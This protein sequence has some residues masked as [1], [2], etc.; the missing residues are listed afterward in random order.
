MGWLSAA[1]MFL[2]IKGIGTSV[3][4]G[5]VSGAEKSAI[6][7]LQGT[8]DSLFIRE[9]IDHAGHR[10][11][12]YSIGES[13]E[14]IAFQGHKEDLSALIP[15]G[16]NIVPTTPE[17]ILTQALKINP[18]DKNLRSMLNNIK[19]KKYGAEEYD[20]LDSMAASYH[21][22]PKGEY[23]FRSPDNTS[24]FATLLSSLA[25]NKDAKNI[26]DNNKI[27]L[28]K[29]IEDSN[30]ASKS[31]SRGYYNESD[32][33]YT[34]ADP[35]TVPVIRS[36]SY[37]VTRNKDGSVDFQSAG[38]HR[39]G[40]ED[41]VPRA[42]IHTTLEAI[43]RSVFGGT[44]SPSETKV[45]SRLSDMLKA[46]GN[47]YNLGP[48]DTWWMKNIGDPLKFPD[49]SIIRPFTD[50]LKYSEELLKRG[51]IKPGEE[52]P[53]MFNDLSS[54]EIL[55]LSKPSY[56][57]ADRLSLL[58]IAPDYVDAS[59]RAEMQLG[60]AGKENAFLDEFALQAAKKQLGIKTDYR[61]IDGNAINSQERMNE[62]QSLGL[63]LGLTKGNTLHKGTPPKQLEERFGD[64]TLHGIGHGYYSS[65]RLHETDTIE[66][67]RMA[68]ANG[69]FKTDIVD[70]KRSMGD[71]DA[72]GGYI[73]FD[74]INKI[75]AATGGLIKN[76]TSLAKYKLPSYEVGSPY[77]PEDQIAQLHKGE[78]VLTAQENKNFSSSGPV[79]NNI[80][81]NGA[82]KDP[83]QIAQEVM[84]QLERMQ[85]KNNKTNLVGR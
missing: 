16:V 4:K 65:Y 27:S 32:Y 33:L 12:T 69:A 48:T 62:I 59:R 83:K 25:G 2:P 30:N 55:H 72:A 1:S 76:K 42:S 15:L 54:K 73:D 3:T 21:F 60:L 13:K 44:W 19:N 38:T 82:D 14:K 84:L 40:Q 34:Q 37:P 85:S 36:V 10:F 53:I 77:I 9:D 74:Y 68:V 8:A 70:I 80:T 5:A 41:E 71:G 46:N 67:M 24:G 61:V 81:I 49:A 79:T 20:L 47:P 26:V 45:V 56:S 50:E 23:D 64:S 52:A 22:N 29:S 75:K 78:R 17:G 11:P 63:S 66:A 57:D 58:K 28:Y 51:L 31:E 7:N 43:V 35:S 18:N 39:L 6:K